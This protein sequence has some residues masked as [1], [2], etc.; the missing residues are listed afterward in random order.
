MFR[1]VERQIT[2]YMG[3]FIRLA[4]FWVI[5]GMLCMDLT[6]I[7]SHVSNWDT[8]KLFVKL[9]LDIS[10]KYWE[11]FSNDEDKV[12]SKVCVLQREHV[13]SCVNKSEVS[14]YLCQPIC[15]FT[16]F[17]VDCFISYMKNHEETKTTF[18]GQVT[19]RQCEG[20][21][22]RV[23]IVQGDKIKAIQRI[24]AYKKMRSRGKCSNARQEFYWLLHQVYCAQNG[25]PFLW[26]EKPF[27][28]RDLVV[29]DKGETAKSADD[30]QLVSSK[31]RD[32]FYDSHFKREGKKLETNYLK[33]QQQ[34][35]RWLSSM[36]RQ[37]KQNPSQKTNPF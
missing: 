7:R 13:N 6:T 37:S 29:I 18:G 31:S 15:C 1:G 36:S 9:Y 26:T 10:L 30:G 5:H 22:D 17:H 27:P 12:C 21:I 4:A 2:F 20:T 35:G 8:R 25:P 11:E 23:A 33:A 14:Q 28:K 3:K 24:P 16:T 19:C 32:S 34:K